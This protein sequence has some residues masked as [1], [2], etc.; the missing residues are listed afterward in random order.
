MHR[1]RED[2]SS[3]ITALTS[4]RFATTGSKHTSHAA[5]PRFLEA[6]HV[7]VGKRRKNPDNCDLTLI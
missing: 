5:L 6:H 1:L 4:R 2:T 3:A 7:I